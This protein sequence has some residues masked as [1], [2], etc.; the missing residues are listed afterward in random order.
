MSGDV[1]QNT[2]FVLSNST[3][4]SRCGRYFRVTNADGSD[5]KK[6]FF[7]E[8]ISH[9]SPENS[10]VIS[11]EVFLTVPEYPIIYHVGTKMRNI[12]INSRKLGA[13]S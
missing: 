5:R 11:Q 1:L 13:Y 10:F 4:V 12:I 6:D 9:N 2:M 8:L 3:D 7:L